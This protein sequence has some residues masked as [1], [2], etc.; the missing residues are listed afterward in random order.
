MK[1]FKPNEYYEK[2]AI[3]NTS[4]YDLLYQESIKNPEY[5]WRKHGTCIDLIRPYTR[6]MEYSF[7]PKHVFIK[8]YADGTLNASAN[9]LD[10]HL[11]KRSTH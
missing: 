9:C 7:D 10:R 1:R 5:F 4:T 3:V 6:V 11:P 8:W 2:H